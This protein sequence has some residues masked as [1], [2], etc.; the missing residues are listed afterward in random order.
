MRPG[1]GAALAVLG[2][3]PIAGASIPA[4][5]SV[6]AFSLPST[7]SVFDV[8]A[9]GRVLALTESG[10][11]QRQAFPGASTYTPLGS[12]PG[13][14]IPSYGPGFVKISP[15]GAHLAIG[16]NGSANQM[17]IVPTA[18]LTTA[19]PTPVQTIGVSNFDA[20]W[21]TAGRLYVSGFAGSAPGLFRIDI[22][23][24]AV[25]TVVSNIGDGSGG[26]AVRA[27][28]IYT[29]IGYDPAPGEPNKGLT[30]SFGQ[31]ALDG[32]NSPVAFSTGTF[33]AQANSGS[34]LGFDTGG[35]L[36]LAGDG[37]VSVFD[38]ATSQRYDLPGLSA[39]GFYSAVF[40]GV[41]GEILVRSY[42]SDTVVRYGIV[43]GP[44]AAG[45]MA[46]GLAAMGR[47]RRRNV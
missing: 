4:Y 31:A 40:D 29:S 9:D 12:I 6:G 18:G 3:T 42:G 41:A 30:R 47:R 16:D 27:G 21:S 43:P 10:A 1:V 33:A 8:A 13:G 34:S 38:L 45:L 28:R 2:L 35:N 26:V 44:A 32:A 25:T 15:D 23:P 20:A 11:I 7:S 37:G 24:S 17:W 39:G 19:G 14:L 36:I 46:V 5:S 22:T